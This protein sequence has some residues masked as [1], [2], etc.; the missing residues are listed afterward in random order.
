MIYYVGQTITDSGVF[1]A[2]TL[3][4][5]VFSHR[6][7]FS[8]IEHSLH[9][10]HEVLIVSGSVKWDGCFDYSI[11]GSGFL[12]HGCD[13]ADLTKYTKMIEHVYSLAQSHFNF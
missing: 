4:I 8:I 5:E 11:G 10:N 6:F 13:K 12:A 7:E 9:N 1:E 3:S 2:H